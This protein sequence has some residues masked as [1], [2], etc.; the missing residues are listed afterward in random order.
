[1]G[2][3]TVVPNTTRSAGSFRK[4]S[5]GDQRDLTNSSNTKARKKIEIANRVLNLTQ[6]LNNDPSN[7]SLKKEISD[8]SR[9]SSLQFG[10]TSSEST[11][12]PASTTTTISSTTT[13]SGEST[14]TSASSSSTGSSYT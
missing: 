2:N 6:L 1:M 14:S 10:K 13:D 11:G 9:Q 12:S 3:G 4:L 5:D 7:S 8:L